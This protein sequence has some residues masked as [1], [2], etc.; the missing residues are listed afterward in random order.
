MGHRG[1]KRFRCL[2]CPAIRKHPVLSNGTIGPRAFPEHSRVLHP[3]SPRGIFS[4][5]CRE[6]CHLRSSVRRASADEVDLGDAGDVAVVG[7][8][9]VLGGLSTS[10][11]GWRGARRG[12]CGGG[13]QARHTMRTRG[14]G[15]DHQTHKGAVRSVYR[16]CQHLTNFT[17]L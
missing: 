7:G 13:V 11:R 2:A 8:A 10:V 14:G 9:G 5:Q 12:W 16:Q 4:R 1:M 15:R 6:A 17:L 3:Q